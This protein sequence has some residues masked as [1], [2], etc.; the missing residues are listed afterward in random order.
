MKDSTRAHA[1]PP[2]TGAP[3]RPAPTLP[4]ITAASLA[5]SFSTSPPSGTAVDEYDRQDVS[6]ILPPSR[7][8]SAADASLSWLTRKASSQGGDKDHTRSGSSSSSQKKTEVV[9]T[10]ALPPQL[11]EATAAA[12]GLAAPLKFISATAVTPADVSE[13]EKKGT[14]TTPRWRSADA[15]APAVGRTPTSTLT[16]SDPFESPPI[17]AANTAPPPLATS[18]PASSKDMPSGL[19]RYRFGDVDEP[20]PLRPST[21]AASG[22][23]E[24]TVT[25]PPPQ[26]SP[27]PSSQTQQHQRDDHVDTETLTEGN[28][29][30]R[31]V[32]SDTTVN[33]AALT[34]AAVAVAQPPNQS[35]HLGAPIPYACRLSSSSSSRSG[36][37]ISATHRASHAANSAVGAAAHVRFSSDVNE[38]EATPRTSAAFIAA[39]SPAQRSATEMRAVV[40]VEDGR[41]DGDGARHDGRGEG[42]SG[43]HQHDF[44]R[45][46]RHEGERGNSLDMP[47]LPLLLSPDE[48]Q[49]ERLKVYDQTSGRGSGSCANNGDG[50]ERHQ[51]DAHHH[52]HTTE[53][54]EDIGDEGAVAPRRDVGVERKESRGMGSGSVSNNSDPHHRSSKAPEDHG[55]VATLDFLKDTTATLL[56]DAFTSMFASTTHFLRSGTDAMV[57]AVPPPL[58]RAMRKTGEGIAAAADVTGSMLSNVS[59][60]AMR[61][62]PDRVMSPEWKYLVFVDAVNV[63]KCS[64]NVNILVA[65]Y[66]FRM[67]GLVGGLLLIVVMQVVCCYYTEVYFKAKGELQSA[68]QVI[69][70]G[71]VPRITFGRWYPTFQLWYEGIAL[72]ATVAYAALN[73]QALLPH[74]HITGNAAKA[75][76]FII[77]SLFCLPLAFMKRART[78]QSMMTLASLLI[79]I[80]LVMMFAVFPYGSVMAVTIGTIEGNP[81]AAVLQLFPP[82]APEFFVAISI[83]VFILTPLSQAVPVE[84]TMQPRRYVKLL[85]VSVLISTVVYI[86]FGVCA[87]V[88]YGSHTCSVLSTSFGNHNTNVE[89]AVM[90]LLFF[91]FLFYIP[92]N[93]FELGE[94]CDRRVLGWR[95]I[96]RY[97]EF[98]PNTLRIFVLVGSA[99]LAW[100]IPYYGLL[101]ALAG[102]LGYSIVAILIPAALD[103]VCRARRGLLRG[104]MPRFLDYV[105]TFSGAALGGVICLVGVIM[106]SYE[107]WLVIQSGY[108]TTC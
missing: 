37:S 60:Y 24:V 43:H 77:P 23:R 6:G 44:P 67:A 17:E 31:A 46:H 33:A 11:F 5:A 57:S 106:T 16:I 75:L 80:A 102:C 81:N 29:E 95:A 65:P 74:M 78:Q 28:K 45:G 53:E 84:R 85:R 93:M 63:L 14:T 98:G 25:G 55:D 50:A 107:M 100:C 103:Y 40:A 83:C 13:E 47:A 49:Q 86:A 19:P 35:S 39:A 27:A 94:L 51:R 32:K 18:A 70:Y 52:Y 62:V 4:H 36:S 104:R 96:P 42:G 90:S 3:T 38:V 58:R 66:V 21:V 99:L 12:S 64:L 54:G 97:G 8:S 61:G 79:F 71:D 9:L 105:I 2:A 89:V 59:A 69:M 48:L 88:S 68:N 73:M 15:A 91:A 1:D 41:S 72:V 92:L 82:S 30:S 87:I 20:S 7:R 108:S 101:I 76:S 22:P 56:P 26:V 10:P 34:T